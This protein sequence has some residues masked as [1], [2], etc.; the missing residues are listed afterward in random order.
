MTIQEY[1]G[2]WCKVIDINEADRIMK[3][4]IASKEKICPLPK[5]V[6]KAFTLCSLHDLKAVFLGLDPYP[7]L[8][9]GKPRATGIAFG[10]SVGTPKTNYSPSLEVLME[11][12]IDFT[13]PHGNVIFDP[14]LEKWE[15]QGVLM[16]NSTLTCLT[17]RVGSHALMWRPFMKS[18]L[19]SLSGYDTGIVY[20]LMGADAQ[21]F[22]SCIN[23][24]YNHIIKVR[25]PSWY[26]RNHTRMPT[27]LWSKINDILIGHYGQGIEWY[28]EYKFNNEDEETNEEVFYAG[29]C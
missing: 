13:M 21:S 8:V 7:D 16:L 24:R 5:N 2:D 26:A 6:F 22:E 14:S 19:T 9:D 25:H 4:L 29:N 3:K 27:D 12:V 1:F 20:V 17:G 11:S 23:P 15:R 28:K 18:F 10:N